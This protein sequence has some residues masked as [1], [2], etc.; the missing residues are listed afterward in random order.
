MLYDLLLVG[1]TSVR[2][3]LAERA[4]PASIVWLGDERF[5]DEETRAI[6]TSRPQIVVD[7]DPDGQDIYTPAVG[8]ARAPSGSALFSCEAACEAIVEGASTKPGA[9]THDH[10]RVVRR[11]ADAFAVALLRACHVRR[12]ALPSLSGRFLDMNAQ[13]G[14][15]GARYRFSFSL[16]R[17]VL[18]AAFP[19]VDGSTLGVAGTTTVRIGNTEQ[20]VCGGD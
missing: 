7:Y 8:A 5:G 11:V 12:I 17:A 19:T 2:A 15:A 9:T 14:Q 10:Q 20:S 6:P 16:H 13:G 3:L 4:V 1:S 18:D